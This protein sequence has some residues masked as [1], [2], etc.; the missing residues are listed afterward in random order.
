M[1]LSFILGKCTTD[2]EK[3]VVKRFRQMHLHQ[4]S[5]ERVHLDNRKM[6]AQDRLDLNGNPLKMLFFIDGM[7]QYTCRTP[8]FKDASAKGDMEIESRIIGV[9]VYCGPIRT[10]FVY[11]TDAIVR[12]GGN[13]MVEIVR[14][15]IIDLTELLR[16]S[17]LQRP[18]T[19]VLQFD[20]CGEN[21]NKVMFQYLSLLIESFRM[22]S[23]E[24]YFLIVGH[25]HA[26][27][28][29]Y[30]STLSTA[31]H[32]A[33]F[34]GKYYY[35]SWMYI[36]VLVVTDCVCGFMYRLAFGADGADKK[37]NQEQSFFHS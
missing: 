30:F 9:E 10:V 24:M 33:D 26:S 7:T 32:A 8:R 19:L 28:D 27:I 34:I 20:N 37:S 21:K 16:Q 13:I 5:T 1:L 31:I 25:T 17:G 12:G 29:Q 6:Y 11:R 14:Q 3:D 36:N 23:V 4:Q 2:V 22:D 18:K 15:S 35:C